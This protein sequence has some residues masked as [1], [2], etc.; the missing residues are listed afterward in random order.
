MPIRKQ[1]KTFWWL[2]EDLVAGMGRPGFNRCHWMDFT[3]EEAILVTWLGKQKNESVPL[4]ELHEFIETHGAKISLFYGLTT[5]ESGWRLA[6]LKDRTNM[7]DHFEMMNEK[8]NVLA[9]V[10][11]V[12]QDGVPYVVFSQNIAQLH[13]ELALLEHHKISVVISLLEHPFNLDVVGKHFSSHHFAIEDLAAPS[14]EQLQEY[15][16]VLHGAIKDKRPVVTH[17]LAGIGRTTTMLIAA[18]LLK[19]DAWEPTMA[20]FRKRNPSYVLTGAQET[21][22]RQ[23]EVGRTTGG[24]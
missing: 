5:D 19:G 3:I 20:R 15:A 24:A 10:E 8:A 22:L 4:V 1:M 12:E 11:I 6:K 13:K 9:D 21:F 18:H 17:C 2:E 7:L 23:F 16:E 14:M